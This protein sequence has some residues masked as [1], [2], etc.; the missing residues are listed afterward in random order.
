MC[1]VSDGFE[2]VAVCIF[3][4]GD[5]DADLFVLRRRGEDYLEALPLVFGECDVYILIFAE[6]RVPNIFFSGVCKV[7][8]NV[9][10]GCG[11]SADII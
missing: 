8:D 5:G 7:I 2:R 9:L 6:R 10:V 1:L 3:E 11:N 4:I